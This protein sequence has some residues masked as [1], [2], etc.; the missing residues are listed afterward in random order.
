VGPGPV[1]RLRAT[2]HGFCNFGWR[3]RRKSRCEQ[4]RQSL[5]EKVER[6]LIERVQQRVGEFGH[7]WSAALMLCLASGAT[8]GGRHVAR[9]K[10]PPVKSHR[11]RVRRSQPHFAVCLMAA[12]GRAGTRP[13]RRPI[14]DLSSRRGWT[15]RRLRAVQTGRVPSGPRTAGSPRLPAC[16]GVGRRARAGRVACGEVVICLRQ[17]F[18]LG[19]AP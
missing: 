19:T 8:A 1:R 11:S 9:V 17:R 16:I 7:C 3:G 15:R 18:L 6:V 12:G 14:S 5:G 4:R 13:S 10:A 2:E